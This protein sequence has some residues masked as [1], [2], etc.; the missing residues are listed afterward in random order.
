MKA[1]GLSNALPIALV[2]LAGVIYPRF[3]LLGDYPRMDE[4]LSV[5]LGELVVQ[6]GQ[7]PLMHGLP[8]EPLALAGVFYLPGFAVLW[9][10]LCDMLFACIAGWLI[11]RIYQEQSAKPV[12]GLLLALTIICPLNYPAVIDAGYKNA[13]PLAFCFLFLAYRLAAGCAA[14]SMRWFWA[15]VFTCF[16]VLFREPF[17]VFAILGLVAAWVSGGLAAATRYVAGGLA[18]LA[19]VLILLI[20]LDGPGVFGAIC[21]AYAGRALL[22]AQETG[23]IAHNFHSGIYKSTI[24]F[25]GPLVILA[26]MAALCLFCRLKYGR[27]PKSLARGAFWLAVFLLPL[28]EPLTKIGFL[29]HFS[30]CLPGLGGLVA[31]MAKDLP[32]RNA[33]SGKIFA[34]A[35]LALC[36]ICACVSV[37]GLP[38]PAMAANSLAMLER[39][40]LKGWPEGL[41]KKS[42]ALAAAS[43]I[44]SLLPPGGTVATSAFSFFIYPAVGAMPPGSSLKG[45]DYGLGDLGRFYAQLGQN[46]DRLI[47]ELRKTPPDVLAIGKAYDAHEKDYAEE[48]RAAIEK[49]GL[50]RLAATVEPDPDR[51]Y[52]WLGYWI[53][54][55]N[56]G[57]E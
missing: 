57:N 40:P 54:K 2:L 45:S 7:L 26:F 41:E 47:A 25:G 13:I 9:L 28:I 1:P 17:F 11:C 22:Y 8:L 33:G 48:L 30:V 19:P 29:Y 35:C 55:R 43:A 3:L 20:C 46:G 31:W 27:S 5:F 51:H 52:G 6:S 42:N 50:Y 32:A 36:A 12:F 21:E 16:G 44:R 14:T 53:Y 15:G 24:H 37:L 10:R 38:P 49:S 23:R 18:G 39:F 34:R 4:G 56:A